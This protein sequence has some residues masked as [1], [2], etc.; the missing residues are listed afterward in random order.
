MCVFCL[1]PSG[2]PS[3]LRAP[4]GPPS[5]PKAQL[6]PVGPMDLPIAFA[7]PSGPSPRP[8]ILGPHE[9]LY[10]WFTSA[11]M[12]LQDA[13]HATLVVVIPHFSPHNSPFLHL[14]KMMNLGICIL[15]SF[16]FSSTLVLCAFGQ[17]LSAQ[18]FLVQRMC[19]RCNARYLTSILYILVGYSQTVMGSLHTWTTIQPSIDTASSILHSRYLLILQYYVHINGQIQETY[20]KAYT[21]IHVNKRGQEMSVE[22]DS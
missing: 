2:P 10:G 13:R 9:P 4:F 6:V 11:Q 14:Y 1:W 18:N 22:Q 12:Q 5:P 21:Y 16:D 3:G 7:R 19:F 15:K 17:H 8:S 20:S